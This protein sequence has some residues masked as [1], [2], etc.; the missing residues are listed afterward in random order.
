MRL[1]QVGPDTGADAGFD[2]TGNVALALDLGY[3]ERVGYL[4]LVGTQIR[5]LQLADGGTLA[6]GSVQ[7][8]NNL[9]LSDIT[10]FRGAQIEPISG[11]YP[12]DERRVRVQDNPYLSQCKAQ[13]LAQPFLDA[14]VATTS[15]LLDHNQPCTYPLCP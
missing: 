2:V 3:L 15:V 10:I 4:R 12:P 5:T 13:A 7:I 6:L 9:Y 14:G 1:R 11:S 8:E